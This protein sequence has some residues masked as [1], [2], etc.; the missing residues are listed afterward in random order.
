MSHTVTAVVSVAMT[1]S[2]FYEAIS[3]G[4]F[5]AAVLLVLLLRYAP[6]ACFTDIKKDADGDDV[7]AQET[8]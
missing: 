7:D 6:Q 3:M 2:F 5:L 8:N 4:M 1:V